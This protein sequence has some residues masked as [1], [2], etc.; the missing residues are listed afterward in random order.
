MPTQARSIDVAGA[1]HNAPIPLGA[2]VGPL[3]CSSAIAGK[4]RSTG[5]LAPTPESQVSHAFANLDAL[6]QA[7]GAS[8]ADVVKLQISLTD[9]GLRDAINREW[10]ARF[11]DPADRPARHISQADL[12]HGMVIQLEVTAYV[13][14]ATR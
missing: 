11:P 1:G 3:L 10:L 9:N 13:Q 5:K 12:Q 6:L 8:L 14:S 2:R 4:D 7:G